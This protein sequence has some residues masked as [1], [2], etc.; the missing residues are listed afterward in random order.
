KL[1]LLD[2]D[3]NPLVPTGIVESDSEVEVVFDERLC[4]VDMQ[5]G[6]REKRKLSDNLIIYSGVGN[7]LNHGVVGLI[8]FGNERGCFPD[9]IGVG[10][11]DVGCGVEGVIIGF[12]L[13]NGGLDR[14]LL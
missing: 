14:E 13:N 12:I 1:R 8:A 5:T 11:A 10:L 6:H 2:N 3:G 7:Q 9:D 4:W